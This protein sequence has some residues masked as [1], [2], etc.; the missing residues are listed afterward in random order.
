MKIDLGTYVPLQGTHT[1]RIPAAI[2]NHSNRPNTM[3]LKSG[4]QAD[5]WHEG[6]QQFYRVKVEKLL[7][8]EEAMGPY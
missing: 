8:V 7:T 3:S 5:M 1:G 2:P 6:T 4:D